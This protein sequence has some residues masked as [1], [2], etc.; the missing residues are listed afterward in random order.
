MAPQPVLCPS[1]VNPG[2]F[3]NNKQLR[4][5]RLLRLQLCRIRDFVETC[6]NR[7]RLM[8]LLA[9]RL[10]LIQNT[11]LFSLTDL[12][13]INS[14]ELP[15]YLVSKID[16]LARHITVE[17]KVSGRTNGR[18]TG[19]TT[20]PLPLFSFPISP[21]SHTHTHTHSLSPPFRAR[22]CSSVKRAHFTANCA[23]PLMQSILLRSAPSCSAAAATPS[24]IAAASRNWRAPQA[25]RSANA[26]GTSFSFACCPASVVHVQ[27]PPLLSD[28]VCLS[29]SLSLSLSLLL[30]LC[31]F[32][33]LCSLRK[34]R[35]L[36]D[37]GS[38]VER[39]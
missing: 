23:V 38:T 33:S 18:T 2:L 27:R 8:Q 1:A 35:A 7:G 39:V 22:D 6:R 13:Q 31:F 25:V 37:S 32:L 19:M 36:D 9:P 5:V 11:E 20:S 30:P 26:F 17:C 12:A 29:L 4:H 15:K 24:S 3:A 16:Q 14:G 10:Y 28:T 21:H 34:E